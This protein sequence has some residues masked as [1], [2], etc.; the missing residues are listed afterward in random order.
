MGRRQHGDEQAGAPA[1]MRMAPTE[2]A[3]APA[4]RGPAMSG[5]AP[6]MAPAAAEAGAAR[7]PLRVGIMLDGLSVRAWERKVVED[8][9]RADWIELAV[10]VVCWSPAERKAS[11]FENLR[12]GRLHRTTETL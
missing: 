8:L 11:W 5:A 9:A 3:A 12:A 1:R 7:R 6:G 4:A 2:T 10:A